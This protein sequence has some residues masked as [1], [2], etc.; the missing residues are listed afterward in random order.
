MK[1]K[2]M[3]AEGR[4]LKAENATR[5]TGVSPVHETTRTTETVVTRPPSTFNLHS[6]LIGTGSSSFAST[7]FTLVELMIS[8][9]MMVVLMLAVN[10]IFSSVGKATGTAQ[11]ISA[12]NRN[13][14]SAQAV[15]Y[16][17]FAGIALDGPFLLIHNER[18]AAFRM[19]KDELGDGDYA[20]VAGTTPAAVD[21]NIR[22]YDLA[23]KDDAIVQRPFLGQR[24]FRLDSIGFFARGTF[25]RQT[26]NDGTYIANQS[27]SE[28]YIR[29]GHLKAP[30]TDDG[31]TP[32]NA[33]DY[34]SMPPGTDATNGNAYVYQGNPNPLNN[35]PNNFY[36]TQWILGRVC[37]LMLP[38]IPK[39]A[40]ATTPGDPAIGIWDNSSPV[41]QSQIYIKRSAAAAVASLAPLEQ[42]SSSA[43]D[44]GTVSVQYARYDVLGESMSQ[45]KTILTNAYPTNPNWWNGNG[46]DFRFQADPFLRKPID[47]TA[48]G[49]SSAIF[50]PACTNFVVEYAGDFV[51]QTVAGNVATT[52]NWFGDPTAAPAIPKTDGQIDFYIDAT[53]KRQIQWYGFPRSTSGL[54]TI[55][56]ANGD[57]VPL[58]DML[59]PFNTQAVF[60]RAPLPTFKADYATATGV[61]VSAQYICA[62]GPDDLAEPR[63]SLIRITMTLDDPNGSIGEPPTYEYVFKL[64]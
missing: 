24:N 26:G 19:R 47:S 22:T 38:E 44:G 36:A 58:R 28:A 21:N 56:L 57:V 16:N 37:M 25:P 18:L 53:G 42:I 2:R 13:V 55:S 8:L 32:A 31:L 59:K 49:R 51:H 11:T 41:P 7:A 30:G 29:Y 63:P 52:D 46:V 3:K 33:P 23:G 4:R 14:Q 35:N 40:T 10:F 54:A 17:D 39:P 61:A 43:S 62:W 12:I 34:A 27:S 9:A 6:R 15:M 64:Q 48:A 1:R 60:E 50:L 20:S 5:V 45:F